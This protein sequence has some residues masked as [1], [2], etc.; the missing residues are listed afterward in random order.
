MPLLVADGSP[1][2]RLTAAVVSTSGTTETTRAPF[3]G[4]A[5]AELPLSTPQDVTEAYAVARAA[6]ADWARRPV[7][8]RA[9]VL[10]RLHDLVLSRQDEVLDLVQLESGKAR[11][12]AFE[13][14]VDVALNARHYARTAKRALAPARRA[15]LVP[16][17]S[18]VHELRHPKGVVGI[19]SP[20][21]YPLTLAVSDA[22]PAFVAGNAVVH[23]PDT[24]TALTALWVRALAVEAGLPANVWQVVL[25]DG[26]TVGRAVVDGG[27]F[28]C[29][30]GSTAVGREVAERCGRRLVGCSLELGGKNPLVVLE[31]AD[32]PRAAAAAVRDCF[33]GA[34]QLCVSMERIYVVEEVYDEFV[35][36]FLHRVRRM[37]PGPALDY[38]ADMGSLLS[39]RQLD[40]V[41]A[42]VEDAVAKGATVL[43]GG[44]PRPDL[45]PLFYEPTVLTGVTEEMALC[46]TETFGP[47]VAVTAV[48]DEDD[49]VRR[50]NDSEYGL[51]ASVWTRDVARGRRLAARIETG[52]VA[53][54]ET[55][56]A[57]WG[58]TAAPM[59]GR[60]ASGL[61]RRHGREGLLRYTEPQ[62]VAVQRLVGFAPP[63]AVPFERWAAG[64]TAAVRLMKA[65]G[66][67]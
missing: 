23:K 42:H 17:L 39:R 5:L 9:R 29:F 18:Q 45:G 8:D 46:R 19:V 7:A 15:G 40:R 11:R 30:T 24:Q 51:N 32:L 35:A 65:A 61:G 33:T 4:E 59:G 60:K 36:E 62:T 49:A 50:A 10:L 31:D 6:Q 63:P 16:L 28:V 47:V 20:W 12:H 13:E 48:A 56:G 44:R 21:N 54:N 58:A 2:G 57:P 34:G 66:R 26:P 38:S 41:V 27:D 67:R 52:T 3:T 55:Y 22:L 25:G 64:F 1:Y 53:V 37:R 43:A 14:V